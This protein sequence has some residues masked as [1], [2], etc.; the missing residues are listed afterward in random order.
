MSSSCLISFFFSQFVS[1][2]LL[3]REHIVPLKVFFTLRD[4][5]EVKLNPCFIIV[6]NE[7]SV[8]DRKFDSVFIG[9][10]LTGF[11]MSSLGPG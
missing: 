7:M 9:L 1:S 11:V 3:Q 8:F 6:E 5:C 2:Q 4:Y 10:F